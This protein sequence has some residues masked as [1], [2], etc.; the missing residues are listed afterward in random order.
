MRPE[1]TPQTTNFRRYITMAAVMTLLLCFSAVTFAQ[2]PQ[3]SLADLLIGLRSQKVTLPERNRILAEAVRER[4]ITFAFTPEIANELKATGADD[5]LI[6][7]IKI[8]SEEP[9]PGPTPAAEP[10]HVFYHRRAIE[11][12]AKGE[13]TLALADF[14]KAAELQADD[15]SILIGRGRTL[16]NMKAYDRSVADF[17]K[18][19]E[20]SPK[21]SSAYYNRGVS[22]ERMGETEKAMADY[23]TAVGIDENNEPAKANLKRL[24]DEIDRAEK[25]R[26]DAEKAEA[27]RK[28]AEADAEAAKKAAVAVPEFINLGVLSGDR[29]VRMVMPV[30]SVIARRSN[31][32]GK[33][34]VEVELDEEGNVVSANAVSG[35]K[36]LQGSA[37]DAAKRSK[38]TPAQFD[39]KPI[40]GKG[41]IIYNFTLKAERD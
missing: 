32:E 38:F 30:Y 6:E 25:K 9:A 34:S 35:P 4:G 23:K 5:D 12:S 36:M 37:E 7:A 14:N 13:Y 18:A 16:F 24:Q 11:N 40:K 29:V 1:N 8:K 28:K 41:V 39:G 19:I 15:P 2:T 33:V 21:D 26:L 17:D 31:I 20:L 3:L 27:E 22:Y 10:D